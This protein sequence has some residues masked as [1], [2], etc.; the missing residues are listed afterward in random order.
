MAARPR[1]QEVPLENSSVQILCCFTPGVADEGTH[2]SLLL[3]LGAGPILSSY[4][5]VFFWLKF[6]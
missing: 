4:S 2:I 3:V 6:R 1:D 5:S